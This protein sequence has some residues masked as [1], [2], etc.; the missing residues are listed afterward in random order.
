MGDRQPTRQID[1]ILEHCQ[2]IHLKMNVLVSSPAPKLRI[3]RRC[4]LQL[5]LQP[6]V[7]MVR[8]AK[9]N[10]EKKPNRTESKVKQIQIRHESSC[11]K[12]QHVTKKRCKSGR[13]RIP[14]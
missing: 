14:S 7:S 2:D 8:K 9:G 4:Q 6:K 5:L 1:A 3:L 10:Q 11:K 12:R 13:K